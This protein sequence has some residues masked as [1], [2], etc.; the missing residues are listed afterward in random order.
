M[1]VQTKIIILKVTLIK[2]VS[3]MWELQMTEADVLM[4]SIEIVLGTHVTDYV[5]SSK[6]YKTM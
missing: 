4:F 2:Y 1:D 5:S 3:E 6:L